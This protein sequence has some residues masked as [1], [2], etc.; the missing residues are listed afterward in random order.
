MIREFDN[1]NLA[2]A[3]QTLA[4]Y[5]AKSVFD[6]VFCKTSGVMYVHIH[7]LWYMADLVFSEC[8]RLPGSP[9]KCIY[10]SYPH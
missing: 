4:L 5:H 8:G 2:S 1:L 10:F 9:M 7:G 6:N 3:W